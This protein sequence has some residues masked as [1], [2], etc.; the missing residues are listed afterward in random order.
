MCFE[1]KIDKIKLVYDDTFFKSIMEECIFTVSDT[2]EFYVT[3][4]IE[5]VFN[6]H[7]YIIVRQIFT[8]EEIMKLKEHFETHPDIKRNAYGRSD[9]NNRTSKLCI[10]NKAGD[11]LSGIVA[12]YT[13]QSVKSIHQI[14][15][16]RER[17]VSN[18]RSGNFTFYRGIH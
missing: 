6:K 8:N 10:W 16:F 7:G 9:G 14:F 2:G 1:A 4:H 12:R 17:L 13:V 5:N 15:V 3:S 18:E 11:D